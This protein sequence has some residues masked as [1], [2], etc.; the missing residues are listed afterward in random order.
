VT[1]GDLRFVVAV[2]ALGAA[3]FNGILMLFSTRRW[4]RLCGRIRLTGPFR[5]QENE[6]RD[7][8]IKLAGGTILGVIGYLIFAALQPRS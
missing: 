2:I 1:E 4:L 3:L 5:E 8:L 6:I 7:L